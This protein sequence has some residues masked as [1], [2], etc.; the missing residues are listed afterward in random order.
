M[1][2]IAKAI[3]DTDAD[4]VEIGRRWARGNASIADGI[5]DHLECG[6]RLLAKKRALQETHGH[7]CWLPWLKANET[8]LGFGERTAQKL[9]RAAETNTTLAADM[10]EDKA[11]EI[12]RR[13]WGHRCGPFDNLTGDSEWY[14]P[15]DIVDPARAVMG[16]IDTDP[17]SSEK[18]NKLVNAA[19]F[20]TKEQDGLQHEWPGNVFINPPFN[21]PAVQDFAEKLVDSYQRGVTRQA[22]WVSNAAVGSR[23]WHDFTIWG[24]V[25]L[26]H[27]R[28]KFYNPNGE[29]Q[30][31]GM[32][33]QCVIYLGER[34][35][36]F[37]ETF[38]AKG[39]VMW[40]VSSDA[41]EW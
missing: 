29:Q 19:T 2:Q 10:T 16:S 34:C 24:P 23:W 41:A 32:F 14:T 30:T 37:I 26:L 7:G 12:N 20:Y 22:I 33:G 35:G 8:I 4:A 38:R 5:R 11:L 18:A 27:K 17:A 25:C 9:M 31:L 13:M 28:I 15:S 40:K 36:Q 3:V 21:H 39:D 6:Q 1:L